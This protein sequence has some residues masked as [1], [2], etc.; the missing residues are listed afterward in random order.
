MA[1]TIDLSVGNHTST[2]RPNLGIGGIGW[3]KCVVD[4]TKVTT[5]DG[6]AA[7]GIIAASSTITLFH[8]PAGSK[9][10][11]FVVDVNTIEGGTL[12]C[13][14]GPHTHGSTEVDADGFIVGLNLNSATGLQ[15]ITRGILMS[16][17]QLGTGVIGAW[18]GEDCAIDIKAMNSANAA[19]AVKF[20]AYILVAYPP[21]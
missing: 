20:T 18:S 11:D 4:A 12:T 3:E 6:A 21:K 9:V 16:D 14:F 10:F 2:T 7:A 8:L 1:D 19:D 13:D 15:R 5:T 17:A